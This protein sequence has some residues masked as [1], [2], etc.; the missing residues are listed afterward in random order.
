MMYFDLSDHIFATETSTSHYILL[1]QPTTVT[2]ILIDH[3]QVVKMSLLRTYVAY[4]LRNIAV[5][6]GVRVTDAERIKGHRIFSSTKNLSATSKKKPSSAAQK[7]RQI[8]F[9]TAFTST[10]IEQASETEKKIDT[11]DDMWP[12]LVRRIIHDT[13]GGISR[14]R[15]AV[16]QAR[17]HQ[18]VSTN[19]QNSKKVSNAR[20]NKH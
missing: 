8:A 9:S 6:N 3:N 11:V 5:L 16:A 19:T 2:E 18:A 17:K 14:R 1:G 12:G 13:L 15:K 10:L 4:R 20:V 7:E